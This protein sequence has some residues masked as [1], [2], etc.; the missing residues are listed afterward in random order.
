[1]SACRR[2]AMPFQSVS[3]TAGAVVTFTPDA[4][5]ANG[6]AYTLNVNGVVGTNG[7]TLASA[8]TASFTTEAL[9]LAAVAGPDRDISFGEDVTLDG[10]SS[11]GTS[12]ACWISPSGG[13]ACSRASVSSVCSRS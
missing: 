1:M 5:L 12:S 7:A 11:A 4:A 2:T 3:S 6:T 9:Q 10:S 13:R 8:Y